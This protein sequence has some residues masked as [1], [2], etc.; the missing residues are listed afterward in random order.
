MTIVEEYENQNTWREWERYFDKLPL[1]CEQTIYDL[2][3]SIGFV[4]NLFAA[5][6]KKVVGFDDAHALL[7]EAYKHGHK[8]CEFI[9]EN[10]FEC[11][12]EKYEKCDGIWSSFSIAYMKEPG[13]FIS[14]WM[15]CLKRGGWF[16]LV[17][18]DG[19][20]SCQLSDKSRYSDEVDLFEKQSEQNKIYDF[21]I[22]RKIKKLMEQ[23]GLE[24]IFEDDDWYDKELN[25]K[26]SATPEIA[27][28]WAAR[29]ERMGTL[30]SHFGSDYSDFC[31]H[32]LETI[33]QANHASKGGVQY[34]IGIK[35]S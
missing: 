7:E 12:S 1:H 14:N 10:I 5:R 21:R 9:Q 28:N 33:S 20:F 17:D 8:N 13:I 22:G 34:Y 24:I 32:F 35:T 19:L 31:H 27:Q 29:L 30:K 25:F 3:C 15:K 4:S 6:V 11:D 26:G 23:N 18:I 16:A 2:G